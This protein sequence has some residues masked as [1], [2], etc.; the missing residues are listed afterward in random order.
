MCNGYGGGII[1]TR[2]E[3]L[4]SFI[5]DV[6]WGA[7]PESGTAD[8]ASLSPSVQVLQPHN[9]PSVGGDYLPENST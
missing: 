3:Q 4:I 2:Q 7:S 8:N 5:Q 9:P 6:S 1:S